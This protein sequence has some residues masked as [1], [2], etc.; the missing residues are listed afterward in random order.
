[1]PC[2]TFKFDELSAGQILADEAPWQRPQIPYRTS[3]IW[4]APQRS[5]EPMAHCRYWLHTGGLQEITRKSKIMKPMA[6][7]SPDEE[8]FFLKVRAV[9]PGIG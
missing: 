1:M 2:A 9:L 7:G 4:T 3:Q 8:D 5:H 6:Y